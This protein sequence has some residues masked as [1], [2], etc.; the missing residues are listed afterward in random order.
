MGKG[1]RNRNKTQESVESAVLTKKQKK[2]KKK[3]GMPRWLVS[4]ISIAIAVVLVLGIVAAV[5]LSNGTFRRMQVLIKSRTGE[6]DV[7]RQVATFLAWE[8]EY[9]SAYIDYYTSGDK[10]LQD[11]YESAEDFAFSYA[12]A[13]LTQEITDSETGEIISTPRD[14]I[15]NTLAYMLNFVAVCDYAHELDEPIT[16]TEEEWRSADLTVTWFSGM[17]DKIPVSFVDLQSMMIQDPT[18]QFGYFSMD[19][20]LD[21]LFGGGMKQKDVDQALKLICLYEKC[22]ELRLDEFRDSAKQGDIDEYIEENPQYFYTVEYLSYETEDKALSEALKA[23]SNPEAFKTVVAKDWFDTQENYKD[24]FNA[25]VTMVEAEEAMEAIKNLVDSDENP[26][27]TNKL[28]ELGA[29]EKTYNVADKDKLHKDLSKWLFATQSKYDEELV[30]TDEAFYVLAMKGQT[31]DKDGD[32]E[33]A[34]V[35]ELTYD[36]VDG[37][38]YLE[39]ENFKESMWQHLLA[40]KELIKDA[41]KVPYQ[42]ALEIANFYKEAWKVLSEDA[43]VGKDGMMDKL[44]PGKTESYFKHVDSKKVYP[45][46]S[47]IHT[48]IVKA[49]YNEEKTLKDDMIL[50]A[51][52]SDTQAFIIYVESVTKK[53]GAVE[54]VTVDYIG[55]QPELYYEMLTEL[56]EEIDDVLPESADAYYMTSPKEDTYQHWMFNGANVENDFK[57]PIKANETKV[58]TETVENEVGTED[59]EDT[60]KYTV[61]LAVEPL[62]L[63][64]TVVANGGYYA[65]TGDVDDALAKF[66]NAE[67]KIAVLE[68]LQLNTTSVPTVSEMID[69]EAIDEALADW[70]F[71]GKREKGDVASVEGKDGKTYIAVYL[72]KDEAW[73]ITGKSYLVSQWIN[74]WV[75]GEAAEYNAREWVLN[76]IGDPAP[77]EVTEE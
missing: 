12:T 33:T 66:E 68:S 38:T 30:K 26:K 46:T 76:L 50:T 29:V 48:S 65:Y 49:I 1:K 22:M 25:Y 36:V 15:D 2:A 37:K 41:P 13:R 45:T 55:V 62:H 31:K 17:E 77:E 43:I 19:Y 51:E 4:T 47:D 24:V 75:A 20:M 34:T 16:V 27:W 71:D 74:E 28:L 54:Y 5:M 21:D 11:Q 53:D 69:R 57:S 67:D 64:S 32:V 61:Y 42:T 59:E 7:N 10:N 3:K 44:N 52:V 8:L 39:D 70:F 35:Y 6:Y 63:D 60:E 9:Y 58:F 73:N 14:A 18:T 56:V 23:A 72:S 40:K